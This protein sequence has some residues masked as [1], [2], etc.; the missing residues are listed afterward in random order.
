MLVW[1]DLPNPSHQ[2]FA[3]AVKHYAR[4]GILGIGTESRGATAT[5]FLNLFLRGQLMWNPDADVPAL[6]V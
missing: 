3:F 1:R 4:A 5:T 6:L 2:A